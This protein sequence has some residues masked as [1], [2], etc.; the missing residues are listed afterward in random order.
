[1]AE[2]SETMQAVKDMLDDVISCV[3]AETGNRE[4]GKMVQRIAMREFHGRY[5]ATGG[6]EAQG[7]HR[8]ERCPFKDFREQETENVLHAYD[9]WSMAV[10][11]FRDTAPRT[12]SWFGAAE[13]MGISEAAL[14]ASIDR[15][16]SDDVA[17]G[18]HFRRLGESGEEGRRHQ[19]ERGDN[20]A[21]HGARPQIRL[22]GEQD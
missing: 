19:P 18:P 22:V 9:R 14:L 4:V 5:G 3:Q 20:A 13:E 17:A 6:H 10:Q 12:E 16:L 2:S 15:M 1:M 7:S 8:R 11:R 21:E